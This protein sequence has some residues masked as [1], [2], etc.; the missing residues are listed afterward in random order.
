MDWNKDSAADAGFAKIDLLSLPVLDQIEE[1]LHLIEEREGARSRGVS[2]E[3]ARTIFAKINGHYMFPESHSHA[4]AITAYQAAWLKRYHPLEFFV[5]LINNQPMGFYPLETLKEDARRFGAP[6]LNP[7]VNASE[8]RAVPDNGCVRLGLRMVKDVGE[9][10]AESIVAERE[11]CGPYAGAGDL[12]RRTGLKP[13]VARSLAEAGA[14]D[15]VA[16]QPPAGALGRGPRHPARP[17]R[18]AR[19]PRDGRTRRARGRRPQRV[20]EDG[21]GVPHAGDIPASPP[22]G[23]RAALTAP[24]RDALRRGGGMPEGTALRVAGWPIARQHPRGEDGTVFVTIKD[25]SGDVQLI[26]AT[27]LRPLP[28]VAAQPRAAR[29]GRGL[30]LG[31]YHQPRR[32]PCRACRHRRLHDRSPRLALSLPGAVSP[33]CAGARTPRRFLAIV[34]GA[35]RLRRLRHATGVTA[36]LAHRPDRAREGRL[37][38]LPEHPANGRPQAGGLEAPVVAG[39]RE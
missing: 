27:R 25:E 5:A 23:V 13:R 9:A 36:L 4:F 8:A 28:P 24:Q 2:E 14:F 15:A 30:A 33:P 35:R 38:G 29:A 6:F 32:L 34:C 26:L 12:V 31:R 11:R 16:P 21:G 3:S 17:W 20:R 10:A 18:P 39:R 7:C 19:L 1:A 37:H 22:D